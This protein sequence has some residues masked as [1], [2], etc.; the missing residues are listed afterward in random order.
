MER[1][2][3]S[4]K[5]ISLCNFNH[6]HSHDND[7]N[8]RGDPGSKSNIFKVLSVAIMISKSII[9]EST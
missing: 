5:G 8:L 7:N 1:G 6:C 2:E 3:I 9:V 4:W